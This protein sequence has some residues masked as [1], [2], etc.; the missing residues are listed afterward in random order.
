MRSAFIKLHLSIFLAGF[1]G[2]FGRLI[3]L[4]EVP[5]VWYR[6]L[7]TSL[8]FLA[9]MHLSGKLHA[10]PLKDVMKI[11]VVGI[12]LALHWIFFYGS[13]K[14]ANVSVAVVCFAL[15]GFFTAL[16][17]PLLLKR[18]FSLREICFSFLSVIGIVLIFHFDTH[19]RVGIVLGVWSALLAAAFTIGNK[20]VGRTHPP[21]TILLY[22]MIG[23]VS[24]ITLLLPFF[25][26]VFPDASIVP[27]FSDLGY[28]FLLAS[29]CTIGMYLFQLQAL[30]YISAF[31]VN[32]SFNLEPVYSIIL[33][34]LFLGEGAELGP[35]FYAGLVL[36]CASVALQTASALRQRPLRM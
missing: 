10:I 27:S 12:L 18:F 4:S 30:Q 28:L 19:F 13:V 20:M 5:L 14:Y 11:V 22:Q 9:Y 1:T 35:P 25:L 34:M 24:F 33:A 3:E 7:L 29:L 23:G 2:I 36:L 6:M 32:L 16:L 31:T 21:T 8:M 17:E 15:A 26:T